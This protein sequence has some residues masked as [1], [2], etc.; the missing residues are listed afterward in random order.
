MKT[1]FLGTTL[2]GIAI[3]FF[4]GSVL[5]QGAGDLGKREFDSN[6]ASCHGP[7]GKGDGP[8]QARLLVKPSDLTA[9][10]KKNNGVFPVAQIRTVID[11]RMEINSHGS[12]VM[13]VWGDDYT[14]QAGTD[15]PNHMGVAFNP[16]VFV[17]SRIMALIDYLN[18][19]QVR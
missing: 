14:E 19:L 6:C 7:S 15:W 10:A 18:R 9:I 17:R 13:P 8:M 5:A 3:T 2:V 4:S 1:T 11:G 16:E 12:R